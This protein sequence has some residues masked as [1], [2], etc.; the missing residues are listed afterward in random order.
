MRVNGLLLKKKIVDIFPGLSA[1]EKIVGGLG[2]GEANH[3]T[4]ISGFS[5]LLFK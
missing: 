4:L 1:L 5:D 3:L 2:S